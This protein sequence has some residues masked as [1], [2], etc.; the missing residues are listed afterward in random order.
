M[1]PDHLPGGGAVAPVVVRRAVAFIDG[2]AS[3]P[4]SVTDV[5]HAAGVGPRALQ[6]AFSATAGEGHTCV[7]ARGR[8]APVGR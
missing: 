2:H 4:I 1:T 3:L 7:L 8:S 5:A 6:L